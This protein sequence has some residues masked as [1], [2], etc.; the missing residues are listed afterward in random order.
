MNNNVNRPITKNFIS[1]TGIILVFSGIVFFME[2]LL[3]T[4]WLLVLLPVAIGIMFYYTGIKHHRNSLV[5]L[6]SFIGTLLSTLIFVFYFI[7]NLDVYQILGMFFLC[8]GIAWL[9]IFAGFYLIKQ[10]VAFWMFSPFLMSIMLGFTFLQSEKRFLDFL[11]FIGLGIGVSLL[12]YGLYWRLFGLVIPG[13]LIIGIIPG[14]YNAWA[15]PAL[16]NP[17][18]QTGIMLVWFALGWGLITIFSRVQTLQFVWWPLIPGGILAMV[19]WGLYIAG[20]PQS[21]VGFIGN[22]GSIGLIIFGIYIL[23]MKR[24]IHR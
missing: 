12:G 3:Q 19:G 13:S 10:K 18:I 15:D 21:A 6:G 1:I 9:F 11:F 5:Y 4:G 17:L 7:Q 24:G 2:N 14:I 22:T 16:N 20:N 23:L 8:L